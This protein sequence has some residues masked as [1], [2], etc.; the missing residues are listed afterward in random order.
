V[1]GS[2]AQY[3]ATLLHMISCTSICSNSVML[4]VTA[5]VPH[6]CSGTVHMILLC[7]GMLLYDT[8]VLSQHTSCAPVLCCCMILF[9]C[10]SQASACMRAL[11]WSVAGE[12]S[13]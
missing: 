9:C 7:C 11:R 6:T 2:P 1:F 13:T 3:A 10:G 12:V 4:T 8:V 5:C